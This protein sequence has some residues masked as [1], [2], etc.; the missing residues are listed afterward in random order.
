[1]VIFIKLLEAGSITLLHKK[2]RDK[3]FVINWRPISLMNDVA[4]IGS[5]S[6]T[7]GM[8]KDLPNII[9]PDQFEDVKDRLISDTKRRID[10]VMW[11]IRSKDIGSMF[12]PSISKKPLTRSI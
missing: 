7:R 10:D 9:H 6:L 8:S 12:V 11:Y 3:R 1:M 5:K 2:Y 4:K